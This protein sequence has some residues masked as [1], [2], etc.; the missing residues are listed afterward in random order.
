MN[1]YNSWSFCAF[2]PSNYWT[3]AQLKPEQQ[4][5]NKFQEQVWMQLLSLFL[6]HLETSSN[7]L[8]VLFFT[9]AVIV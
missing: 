9:S 5:L 3:M 7:N 8:K 4:P 1:K 2:M 6:L